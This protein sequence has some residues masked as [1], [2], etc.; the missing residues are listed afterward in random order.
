LK[1]LVKTF[2]ALAALFFSHAAFADA[3]QLHQGRYLGY[4]QPDGTTTKIALVMDLYVVQP[5]DLTQ[6]PEMNA[7]IRLGLGGPQSSEYATQLYE[8]L[9]YDY[10]NGVL[11]IDA[12]EN[13][14]VITAQVS[15]TEFSAIDGQA[16]VR[17]SALSAT[18]HLVE[19]TDDPDNPGTG[20][21]PSAFK[22]LLSGEYKGLCG[23]DGAVL[24]LEI[25]RGLEEQ[26]ED[27]AGLA[28]YVIQGRLGMRGTHSGCM[29]SVF[30]T[31]RSYMTAS[32]DLFRDRLL[33]V[34][35]TG[36]DVDVM[37]VPPGLAK[38]RG[39]PPRPELCMLIGLLLERHEDWCVESRHSGRLS[40][41]GD[42][43]APG[44]DVLVGD[45]SLG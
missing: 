36:T 3:P 33:L 22:P 35:S 42:V 30:C 20:V 15:G 17:S 26:T 27:R 9:R 43:V 28:R 14:L 23:N 4:L 29:D 25:A 40:L 21:P 37:D 31:L 19:L 5:N 34:T 2:G 32:F 45:G 44:G 8:N 24:Q 6:F 41:Q 16:F 7:L 1:R 13:D 10:D 11:S 38:L 18:I 12:P 39:G